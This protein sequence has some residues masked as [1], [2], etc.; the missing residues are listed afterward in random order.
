M[1]DTYRISDLEQ[2]RLLTDPLK[3]RLIQE[4]AEG[5]RTV[6]AVAEA[7]G[8]NVTKLYRHVDALLDAGL[9][10]VTRERKK[11]GTVERT[12]RAVARRFE[13]EHS[14]FA[15]SGGGHEAIRELLRGGEEELLDAMAGSAGDE[16][17]ILTRLRIKVSPE[18]LASL[19]AGLEA[20]LET[21]LETGEEDGCDA[22][23]AEEAG[24]MIAFYRIPR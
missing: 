3:L 19:R 21:L 14:L 23:D 22:E 9:I 24:V 6:G 16:K 17:P 2:V 5:P 11:R 1:L 13:V 8:E 15:D 20:W 7:L 4:F 12:F 18:R 10:E